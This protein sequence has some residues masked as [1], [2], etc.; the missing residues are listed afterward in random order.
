M[1]R[2]DRE[3]ERRGL[4][5]SMKDSIPNLLDGEEN[6][7][8]CPNFYEARRHALS[9]GK[10]IIVPYSD[11]WQGLWQDES[12]RYK[13]KTQ[14]IHLGHKRQILSEAFYAVSWVKVSPEEKA[15]EILTLEK[16]LDMLRK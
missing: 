4:S 5:Y 6:Y 1:I 12:G 7:I 10:V 9:K 13:R 2:T 15:E 8:N 16:K 3:L 14:A 11:L